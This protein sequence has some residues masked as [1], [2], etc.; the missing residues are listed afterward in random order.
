MKCMYLFTLSY[1]YVYYCTFRLAIFC[2]P[3][4]SKQILSFIRK[5]V[6]HRVTSSIQLQFR[7]KFSYIPMTTLWKIRIWKSIWY[8]SP[9]DNAHETLCSKHGWII[10][11]YVFADL[12]NLLKENLTKYLILHQVPSFLMP[13]D[14]K[15][16]INFMNHYTTFMLRT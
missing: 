5:Y 7:T 13:H 9:C 2:F 1:V 6:R 4:S 3:K 12:Y 10:L 8:K 15:I 11:D 14:C 16:T